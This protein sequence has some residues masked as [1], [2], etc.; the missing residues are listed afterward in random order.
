M[1]TAMARPRRRKLV[2]VAAYISINLAA[3]LFFSASL[4]ALGETLRLMPLDLAQEL[5]AMKSLFQGFGY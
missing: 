3:F 1:K 5:A 2:K 4:A